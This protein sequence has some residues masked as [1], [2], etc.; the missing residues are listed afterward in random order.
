MSWIKTIREKLVLSR[1]TMGGYLALSV[2]TIEAVELDQR[3]LK[4]HQR[5]ACAV[6]EEAIVAA[7]SMDLSAALPPEADPGR[8]KTLQIRYNTC[9]Q[10][11]ER[12]TETL[13]AMKGRYETA[14]QCWAT[15]R[16]LKQ[17]PGEAATAQRHQWI[18]YRL[19]DT[20]HL[21]QKNSLTQQ[22]LLEARIAGLQAT[23]EALAKHEAVVPASFP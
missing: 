18:D 3:R 8:A 6:L 16:Y 5:M 23:M 2:R 14:C 21:L 12:A 15:Y 10:H 22:H 20:L 4:T 7:E 17:H 9:R 13:A 1:R 11:L 19:K